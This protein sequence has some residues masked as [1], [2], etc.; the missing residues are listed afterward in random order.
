[1]NLISHIL[2]IILIFKIIINEIKGYTYN[3]ATDYFQ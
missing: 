2:F 1:M 3:F